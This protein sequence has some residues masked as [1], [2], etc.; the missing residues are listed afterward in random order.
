MNLEK[1]SRE[2]LIELCLQYAAQICH[3]Q[4]LFKE[5]FGEVIIKDPFSGSDQ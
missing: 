3:Q 2:Q 4:N 1:A 5:M